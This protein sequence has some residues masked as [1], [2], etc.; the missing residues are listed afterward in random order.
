MRYLIVAGVG[1]I[2]MFMGK[3]MISVGGTTAFYLLITYV[4]TIKDN[5]VE[6]LY[7]LLVSIHLFRLFLL[8]LMQLPIFSWEFIVSPWILSSHAL[9]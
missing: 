2:M 3:V 6:P 7:L 1:E 8:F 9:S 5:I 4:S